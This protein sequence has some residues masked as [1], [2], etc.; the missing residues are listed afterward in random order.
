MATNTQIFA[1]Q[2]ISVIDLVPDEVCITHNG[3]IPIQRNQW[4]NQPITITAAPCFSGRFIP[5]LDTN[6]ISYRIISDNS[7][8]IHSFEEFN[9]LN[10]DCLQPNYVYGILTLTLPPSEDTI[11]VDECGNELV[12][13]THNT[14]QV[15]LEI[16][17]STGI[18]EPADIVGVVEFT[19]HSFDD[20]S[21]IKL[22]SEKFDMFREFQ[23]LDP[24]DETS[25]RSL[26]KNQSDGN[27][28][29]MGTIF[30]DIL[31]TNEDVFSPGVRMFSQIDDFQENHTNIDTANIPQLYSKTEMLGTTIEDFGLNLPSTLSRFMDIASI[32]HEN[33]FGHLD[34]WDNDFTLNQED[35]NLGD[36]VGCDDIVNVGEKLI[37]QRVSGG[38]WMIYYAEDVGGN[39]QFPLKDVAGCFDQPVCENYCFFRHKNQPVVKTGSLIDR[40][41]TSVADISLQEWIKDGGSM[42][43][44]FDY[45]LRKGI[46]NE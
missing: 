23:N 12:I 26:F 44:T 22:K 3:V 6:I 27:E 20:P 43:Q 37:Y 46:G 16:R 11:T 19:L 30:R 33:L 45:I 2:E 1:D 24:F 7:D 10:T 18:S 36:A 5:N 9:P 41:R 35:S 29:D 32:S 17:M 25:G 42:E 31:G 28:V 21:G 34:L 4:S 13:P 38:S 40:E 39:E 8:I 15:G 14:A